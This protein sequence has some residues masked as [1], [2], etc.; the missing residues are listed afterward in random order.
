[1]HG[2]ASEAIL[3]DMLRLR[4]LL[5]V[6]ACLL[7]SALATTSA[8]A[9][10]RP[11]ERVLSSVAAARGPSAPAP[12]RE[13]DAR[14]AGVTSQHVRVANVADI[15]GPVPELFAAAQLAVRAYVAYFNSRWDL[16]GRT[17]VLD[18]HDSR[19][20]A[21]ADQRAY[22]QVCDEDLAAI[23]SMSAFDNGGAQTAD[24]CGLPDLRAET[25]TATRR[26][27]DTCLAVHP[28]DASLASR[29]VPR[30]LARTAP[31]TVKRAA[32]LYLDDEYH[33]TAAHAALA[34]AEREGWNVVYTQAISSAES[35]YLPYA[36]QLEERGVRLV[37]FFGPVPATLR[38]QQA[39]RQWGY[40]PE[41]FLQDAT[42]YS[43]DY[44]RAAG[45]DANGVLVHLP[46]VLL[47]DTSQPALR[48]YRR[49]LH[50]T[51]PE[52]VP[53]NYGLWAWSAADLALTMMRSLRG[54]LDREGLLSA[55]RAT[56]DWTGRGLHALQDV[57]TQAESRCELL[58]Q[59]TE[60]GW[61]Q[62]QPRTTC[63]ARP[64]GQPKAGAA[65]FRS[66]HTDFRTE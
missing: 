52:A 60:D 22:L 55:L 63:V 46:H 12:C 5:S 8:A 43:R 58:V 35:I 66:R 19:T 38:L 42:L 11:S 41:T 61:T 32:V 59:R 24:D 14:Q 36:Q 13:L 30:Y 65:R 47:S 33:A 15:T 23:G 28:T 51:D 39:M 54:D 53:T 18:A 48:R 17:V 26:G 49:W 37:H 7:A 29:A 4:W 50:Q 34:A 64:F 9:V 45:R 1:M 21:A 6:S 62:V 31:S 27:C 2:V 3:R 20:D 57:G 44:V 56:R 10:T 25:V 40:V 16:C